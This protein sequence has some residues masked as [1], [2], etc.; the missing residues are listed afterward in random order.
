[1]NT[2]PNYKSKSINTGESSSK[3]PEYIKID[4]NSKEVET[5]IDLKTL[6]NVDMLCQ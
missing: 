2:K 3:P 4:F 1:M 6:L 5:E